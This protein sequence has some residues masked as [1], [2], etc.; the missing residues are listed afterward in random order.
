MKNEKKKL[1]NAGVFGLVVV[2]GL[3]IGMLSQVLYISNP[4]VIEEVEPEPTNLIFLG[5]YSGLGAGASGWLEIYAYPHAANPAATYAENTSAT[6]EAASL[7]YHDTDGWTG[8]LASQTAFDIVVRV[9]YNQTH[10]HNGT[11]FI[12]TNTRVNLTFSCTSWHVGSDA[13]DTS[14]T[15][16]VSGN[17][18]AN[19]FIWENFYW[20]NGGSGYEI[21]DDSTLT[22][23]APKQEAKY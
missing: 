23:N 10:A 21:D 16:V 12:D 1:R 6:L 20:N 5:E 13:S 18:S 9:R 17:N 14:G 8:D 3:V 19:D 22:V 4:V 11:I 15:C 2:A 7:A